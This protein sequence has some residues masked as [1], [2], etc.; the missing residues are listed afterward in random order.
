[1]LFFHLP[2][3]AAC[4]FELVFLLENHGLL[5]ARYVLYPHQQLRHREPI[6]LF[7]VFSDEPCSSSD[8]CEHYAGKDLHSYALFDLSSVCL[9]SFFVFIPSRMPH[10]FPLSTPRTG[11][12]SSPVISFVPPDFVLPCSF[13]QT[14]KGPAATQLRRP[15]VHE[16][17][18]DAARGVQHSSDGAYKRGNSNGTKNE[19]PR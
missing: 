8:W 11:S 15:Q 4:A 12:Y 9:V 17:F 3:F 10:P 18:G 5:D 19:N 13:A 7:S 6:S 1:M 14:K 2:P 16:R